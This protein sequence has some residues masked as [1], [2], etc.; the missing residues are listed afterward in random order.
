MIHLA[1]DAAF[2]HDT[3]Q[4]SAGLV[5]KQNGQQDQDKTILDTCIDNHQAEFLAL[6]WALSNYQDQLKA[7]GLLEV[8]SDSKILVASLQKG[9][10]KNYQKE[11]DLILNL[12]PNPATTFFT[13]VPE[14]QN[15]GPH[16]LALQA[17]KKA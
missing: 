8:L 16:H 9:Y 5:L 7:D 1:I 2:Q 4:A 10:A 12:L 17:L 3:H 6:I 13:W 14:K 15:L 11:V